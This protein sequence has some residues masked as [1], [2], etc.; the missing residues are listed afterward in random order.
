MVL[1][2]QPGNRVSADS[3]L[4]QGTPPFKQNACLTHSVDLNLEAL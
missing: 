1:P 4:G 2:L 3:E